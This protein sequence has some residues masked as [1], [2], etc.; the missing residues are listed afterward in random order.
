[1]YL[2]LESPSQF[3]VTI[4]GRPRKWRKRKKIYVYKKSWKKMLSDEAEIEER[5]R[6]LSLSHYS[7]VFQN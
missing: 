1:M 5:K 4:D 7:I 2:A 6:N 3:F